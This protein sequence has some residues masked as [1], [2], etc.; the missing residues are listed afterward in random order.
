MARWPWLLGLGLCALLG[1]CEPTSNASSPASDSTTSEVPPTDSDSTDTDTDADA[2]AGTSVDVQL[3]DT[4]VVPGDRVGP[5]TRD[6]SRDRLVELF[7]EAALTDTE[8]AVGEGFTESGTV[9][10]ANGDAAFAV[11]WVDDSQ[12]APATVKDFGPAWETPEGIGIGTS[13]AE[14]QEIL[15]P[16]ELYG[17]GWD[18]GGTLV[19]EG[20]E[21]SGYYGSLILRVQPADPE[22]FQQQS[23]AFQALLG[24]KLIASDNPSLPDL[25]LVVDE[26]IVYI[27]P[28]AE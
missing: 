10:A 23:G 28:P 14:L 20:S 5:I 8:V 22:L 11:I 4:V 21:L 17:F 26:M 2:D 12:A 16:F 13:F 6:T 24:D 1:A 19:L 9:V 15:G 7:G 3:P 27:N 18:Y 25:N